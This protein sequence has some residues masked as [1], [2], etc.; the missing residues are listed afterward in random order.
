MRSRL[1]AAM[2]VSAA[3]LAVS[4]AASSPPKS[5]SAA[6]TP[7]QQPPSATA[8]APV[9]QKFVEPVKGRADVKVT[10]PVVK[11]VGHDVVTTMKVKNLS[12]APIAGLRVDE[13]WFDKGG[14]V[15]TGDRQRLMKPLQPNEIAVFQLRSPKDP[16]MFSNTYQFSHSN[17]QV[18]TDI[19]PKL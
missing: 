19:V 13:Y 17:G 2:V 9:L 1:P 6:A 10:K 12:S 14:N 4:C 16:K 7:T 11:V 3:L 5:A 8:P 15:V 18:H